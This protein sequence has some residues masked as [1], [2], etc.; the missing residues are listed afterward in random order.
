MPIKN[1]VPRFVDSEYYCGSFGLQWVRYPTIQSD[2]Y[3]GTTIFKDR[4]QRCLGMPLESLRGKLVLETGCGSGNFT[5][6]LL[7]HGAKVFACDLSQAIDANYRRFNSHPSYFACQADLLKVPVAEKSFDIVLCMGVVQST[8]SP[9]ATIKRLCQYV[10][11]GG[12]VIFDHYSDGYPLTIT[13][14]IWRNLL[15]SFSPPVRLAMVRIGC[16]ILWP[17]HKLLWDIR[18]LPRCYKLRQLLLKISPLVDLFDAYPQ[19][20]LD[21]LRIWSMLITHDMVTDELLQLRT[22]EQICTCLQSCGVEIQ[23]AEYA[24]NGVEIRARKI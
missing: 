3:T 13:R 10:K 22:K 16:A 17:I 8:P 7:A 14:R 2:S 12:L 19:L 24:G 6:I 21:D 9:E 23:Y 11:P 18:T 15:L 20:R 5:E 1:G 4:L